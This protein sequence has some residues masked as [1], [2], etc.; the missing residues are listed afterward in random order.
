MQIL[1]QLLKELKVLG[2]SLFGMKWE[3]VKIWLLGT[4]KLRCYA[5]VLLNITIL[6][7]GNIEKTEKKILKV[8]QK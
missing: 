3:L 7:I 4:M 1:F 5:L 6:V 2:N 8:S